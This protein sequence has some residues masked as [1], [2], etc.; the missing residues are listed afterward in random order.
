MGVKRRICLEK[1]ELRVEKKILILLLVIYGVTIVRNGVA[2]VIYDVTIIRNGVALV[3]YGVTIVRN[4]VTLV[5]FGVTIVRN[6]ITLVI[7]GVT[8]VRNGVTLVIFG[9]TIVRNGVALVIYGVTI[10][11]NGVA[12]VTLNEYVQLTYQKK[13]LLYIIEEFFGWLM[14]LE[15]TTLGTTNRCSNQTE[16][17]PPCFFEAAKICFFINQEEILTRKLFMSR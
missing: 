15:P 7:Y 8:I 14:G 12:L 10:I 16:L 4:G 5:I 1:E 3:I 6:G 2:L 9:V 13:T 11:R 17:Q